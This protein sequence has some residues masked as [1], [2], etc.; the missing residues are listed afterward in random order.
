MTM[1]NRLMITRTIDN[2]EMVERYPEVVR[3]LA[4]RGV[5]CVVCGEPVWGTL[6]ELA[7]KKDFQK[8]RSIN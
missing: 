6:E 7:R 1:E 8:K 4:D 3:P 2:E 5:F